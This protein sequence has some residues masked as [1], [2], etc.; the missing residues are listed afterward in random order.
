LKEGFKVYKVGNNETS[1]Y[2]MN[3]LNLG[4][5]TILA[6]NKRLASMLNEFGSKVKV[7][8]VEFEHIKK[9]YGAVHCATQVFRKNY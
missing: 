8:Y 6:V 5:N 2:L 1:D 4:N 3:F 9:M 7:D